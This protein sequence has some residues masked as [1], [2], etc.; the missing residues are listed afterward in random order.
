M[1]LVAIA[2]GMTVL[3]GASALAQERHVGLKA[4]V[5]YARLQIEPDT[6]DGFTDGRIRATGGAFA[7]LPMNPRFAL[8]L[9]AL[10]SQKGASAKLGNEGE[11]TA[12][13]KLDYLDIPVLLRIEGPASGSK[14]FHVFAGPSASLRLSAKSEVEFS[15]DFLSSGETIDVSDEVE[16]FD[17]GIV[18]GGGIHIG[19][20][21]VI[22]GRYSWGLINANSVEDD[23]VT[24]KHRVFA[25][26]AGVRF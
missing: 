13:L 2:I 4:G 7:V 20:R 18:V 23:P 24:I 26:M 3:G 10:F 12:T 14:S 19:R 8:Q 16:R 17:V 22:D 5:S 6:D 25:V 1:R 11:A 21:L 15:G 9:E